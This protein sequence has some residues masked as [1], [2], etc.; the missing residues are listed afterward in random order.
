M[1]VGIDGSELGI[2]LGC[3]E[4]LVEGKELGAPEGIPDG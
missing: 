4:G 3:D 2:P 1:N